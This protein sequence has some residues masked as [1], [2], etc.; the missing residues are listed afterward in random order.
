MYDSEFKNICKYF[1]THFGIISGAIPKH[2]YGGRMSV[3][4]SSV[5]NNSDI[6]FC[7]RVNTKLPQ[8]SVPPTTSQVQYDLEGLNKY[9]LKDVFIF[10][11]IMWTD[12]DTLNLFISLKDQD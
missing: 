1:C 5:Q 8:R 6:G 10:G 12:T 2:A 7:P 9:D 4:N 3:A 11:D